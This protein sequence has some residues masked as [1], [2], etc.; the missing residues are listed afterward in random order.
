MKTK[1]EFIDDNSLII[2]DHKINFQN[3]SKKTIEKIESLSKL[4]NFESLN[5]NLKKIKINQK[6]NKFY[7]PKFYKKKS[8]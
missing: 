8:K 1:I 5:N 2:P 4:K 7:K 3:K 6:N